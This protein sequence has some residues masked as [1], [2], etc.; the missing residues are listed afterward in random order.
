MNTTPSSPVSLPSPPMLSK[1]LPLLG[2]ALEFYRDRGKLLQRGHASLG[3]I[4]SIQLANNKA[5][6]LIGPELAT[7]FFKETDKAL[8]MSKPY[9]FLKPIL[10]NVAF[11]ASHETY[12]NQRPMLYEPFQREKMARYLEIMDETV[13]RWVDHL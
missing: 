4:F 7:L 3:K 8:D 10:G 6:V 11:V 2:H 5:V 1:R 12:M 13:R 9:Q